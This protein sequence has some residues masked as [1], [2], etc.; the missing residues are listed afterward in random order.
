MMAKGY[1]YKDAMEAALEAGM[2]GLPGGMAAGAARGVKGAAR[3][4]AD[5]MGAGAVGAEKPSMMERAMKEAEDT[6]RL[7]GK[8]YKEGLGMKKGGKVSSA[9]AR[10]DGCAVRGKTKGRMI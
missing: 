2:M 5:A 6:A 7:Y 1:S 3:G 4:M 9:S 10:A 8:S